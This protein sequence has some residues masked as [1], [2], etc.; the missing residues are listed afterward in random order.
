MSGTT[1]IGKAF[2]MDIKK[3]KTATPRRTYTDGFSIIELMI[4]VAIAGLLASIAVPKYKRYLNEA[5]NVEAIEAIDKISAGAVAYHNANSNFPVAADDDATY[6]ATDGYRQGTG[7]SPSWLT[8]I[9]P[10]GGVATP[11]QMKEYFVT[12]RNKYV[13]EKLL[14]VPELYTTR[15]NFEYFGYSYPTSAWARATATRSITCG[16]GG[17]WRVVQFT[18]YITYNSGKLARSGVRKVEYEL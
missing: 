2:F 8:D 10:N 1:Q 16:A 15:F 18:R 7:S 6:P 17:N 11:A 5:R 3:T 9:C 13:W 14:F 4:T 12:R